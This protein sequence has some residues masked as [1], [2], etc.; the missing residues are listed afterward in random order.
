MLSRFIASSFEVLIEVA[1][2]I[3]LLGGTIVGYAFGRGEGAVAGLAISFVLSV[4]LFGAV[5]MLTEIHK[6]VRL[7]ATG[8]SPPTPETH[9]ICPDCKEFVRNTA[10][11]C[12][13]CGSKLAPQV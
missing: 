10:R 7:L 6:Y 13:H 2:W 9:V 11:V 8:K 12:S 3:M 1:L 5:L 4:L